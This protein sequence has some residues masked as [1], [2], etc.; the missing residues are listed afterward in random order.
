MTDKGYCII[1]ARK[2]VENDAEARVLYD[3]VKAK[4]SEHPEVEVR[5]QF[6]NQFDLDAS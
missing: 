2:E 4:L 3:W 6:S 1:T 5:G